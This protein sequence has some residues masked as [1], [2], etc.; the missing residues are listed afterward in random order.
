MD[1]DMDGDCVVV[2]V[3]ETTVVDREGKSK[4]EQTVTTRG[5]VDDGGRI[6]TKKSVLD[7][8]ARAR[9]KTQKKKDGNAVIEDESNHPPRPPPLSPPSSFPFPHS[10]MMMM[11]RNIMPIQPA[12]VV[13]VEKPP[14]SPPEVA[15][16]ATDCLLGM[17]ITDTSSMDP[18]GHTAPVTKRKPTPK[19]SLSKR[20]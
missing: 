17:S 15:V 13:V 10:M 9:S 19:S 3:T 11:M 4:T 2:T 12:A 18:T 20:K 7:E 5:Y 1:R 8:Q 6:E 16:I 14:T